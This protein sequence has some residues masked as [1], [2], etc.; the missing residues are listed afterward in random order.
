MN[1]ELSHVD[2]ELY[3][4]QGSGSV[5]L[6]NVQKVTYNRETK[7]PQT[8]QIEDG[9]SPTHRVVVHDLKGAWTKDNR[10]IVI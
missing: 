2:I 10:D 9:P 8:V 1:S 5:S 6:L 3:K 7:L 4:A